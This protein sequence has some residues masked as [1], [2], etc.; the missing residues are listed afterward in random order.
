MCTLSTPLLFNIVLEFLFRAIRKEKK[1]KG[2]GLITPPETFRSKSLFYK[3]NIQISVAFLYINKE[4]SGKEIRKNNP[5][6]SSL[7][8]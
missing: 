1:I 7:K 2:K 6:H 8:K 4:H 5:M 3:I